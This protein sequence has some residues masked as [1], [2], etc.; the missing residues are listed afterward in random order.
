MSESPVDRAG[1]RALLKEG[2]THTLTISATKA[3]ERFF[4]L[5]DAVAADPTEIVLVEHKGLAGRVMVASE[6][7][8]QYTQRLEQM[9]RA[10]VASGTPAGHRFRLAGSLE[11]SDAAPAALALA[12]AD[13]AAAANRKFDDL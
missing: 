9:L 3:R 7:Y 5:L 12:R 13:A 6:A 11:V 1:A 4:A 8:H 2:S 10:T